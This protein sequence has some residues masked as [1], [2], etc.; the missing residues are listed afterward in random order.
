MARELYNWDQVKAYAIIAINN[1]KIKNKQVNINTEEFI[2]EINPLQT[3]YGKEGIVG[4]A[5]RYLKE[6]KENR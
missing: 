1:L 3:L 2:N 6:D 5:N 4:L